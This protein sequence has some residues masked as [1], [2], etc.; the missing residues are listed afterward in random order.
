M[1]LGPIA[2]MTGEDDFQRVV[3][4]AFPQLRRTS[5]VG[6]E[7]KGKGS[8]AI[9]VVRSLHGS[10][11]ALRGKGAFCTP[12]CPGTVFSVPADALVSYFISLKKAS[13]VKAVARVVRRDRP[14]LTG[15]GSWPKWRR[16]C[17]GTSLGSRTGRDS[18]PRRRRLSL[19]DQ[20]PIS[21][22]RSLFYGPIAVVKCISRPA[23]ALSSRL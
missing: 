2:A 14:R 13:S 7:C 20:G 15:S 1:D 4:D 5:L 16:I 18:K 9:L 6:G 3:S 19:L 12:E 23:P 8:A 10:S 21:F 11:V 22:L 17:L